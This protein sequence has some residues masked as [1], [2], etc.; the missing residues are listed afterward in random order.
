MFL[1]EVDHLRRLFRFDLPAPPGNEDQQRG[2]EKLRIIGPRASRAVSD[3]SASYLP[4]RELT[5][6]SVEFI[7][8]IHRGLPVKR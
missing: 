6:S 8:Q 3:E 5:D 1:D 7:T 4:A 2:D